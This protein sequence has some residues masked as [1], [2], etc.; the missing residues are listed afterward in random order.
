[1]QPIPPTLGSYEFRADLGS[2]GF[3]EVKLAFNRETYQYSA[4]KVIR[5][6]RVASP[7]LLPRFEH[8]LRVM[9]RLRH[10]AIVRL[11]DLRQ[12]ELFY[13]VFLDLCA[14]GDLFSYI[15]ERKLLPET[16][17]KCLLKQILQALACMHRH[18]IAHR[19][20]KP[21]NILI[22]SVRQ[23][24]IKV[25]DFGLSK[26][27]APETLTSTMT[28]S[29][30]YAAPEILSGKSYDPFKSDLWACGVILYVMMCGGVPW[31]G[32]SIQDVY[33]QIKE[34]EYTT[35]GFLSDRCRDLIC[36]LM[37]TDP[38]KRAT[39]ESALAHPWMKDATL[40][41]LYDLGEPSQEVTMNDVDVF[42]GYTPKEVKVPVPQAS[43]SMVELPVLEVERLIVKRPNE[44]DG[45]P[46]RRLTKHPSLKMRRSTQQTAAST[47]RMARYMNVRSSRKT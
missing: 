12:D 32:P 34:G 8:E 21:E 44:I 15:S 16:D 23:R 36:R 13:Y 18:D 5:K 14:E 42:F 11:L 3:S 24:R 9:V 29:P 27:V 30:C 31:T 1:M 22:E 4:C 38:E 28:G 25:A 19:D 20:L 40:P 7:D 37:C 10:H 46:R 41:S 39:I 35:P 47:L 6:S 33:R 45:D 17:A 43:Q 26:C 2:G